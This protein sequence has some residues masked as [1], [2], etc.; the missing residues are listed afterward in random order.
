MTASDEVIINV[1]RQQAT[2]AVQRIMDGHYA[3]ADAADALEALGPALG[4]PAGR[5]SELIFWPKERGLST[6]EVVERALAYRPIAL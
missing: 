4:C 5:V 2:E 3:G 1:D 6:G